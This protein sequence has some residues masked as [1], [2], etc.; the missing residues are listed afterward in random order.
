M[1][2]K[3]KLKNIIDN[4][5]NKYNNYNDILRRI[6][7]NNS[8]KKYGYVLT[9]AC[10]VLVIG[11]IFFNNFDKDQTVVLDKPI[12]EDNIIFN[13]ISIVDGYTS[14]DAYPVKE[15]I[16]ARAVNSNLLEKFSFLN[17][18]NVP[19]EYKMDSMFEVYVKENLD[20]KEYNKIWQYSV[21]YMASFEVGEDIYKTIGITFTKEDEM[22]TCIMIDWR[23]FP[24]ST[25]NGVEV[26]IYQSDNTPGIMAY[27][28]YDGY[29]FYIKSYYL[30]QDEFVNLVKSIIK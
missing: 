20:S 30:S 17:N 12:V 10:F 11:V 1:T 7:G 6:E 9:F 23:G 28:E 25:I 22:L 27:F 5:Y 4:D 3:D 2:N 26:G 29:K 18:L 16:D 8:M 24:K 13:N 19:D 21:S 15:D 14:I